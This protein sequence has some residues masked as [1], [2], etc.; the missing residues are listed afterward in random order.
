M[1]IGGEF[2]RTSWDT[3]IRHDGG[4]EIAFLDGL[5]AGVFEHALGPALPQSELR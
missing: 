3:P 5:R 4:P 2:D 1:R